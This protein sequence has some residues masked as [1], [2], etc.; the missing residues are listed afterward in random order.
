[1]RA[2]ANLDAK[3]NWPP[4]VLAAEK[5]NLQQ[6]KALIRS[7]ADL[8]AP[9]PLDQTAPHDQWRATALIR[10]CRNGF[11]NVARAL[12]DAG[13]DVNAQLYDKRTALDLAATYDH[14]DVVKLLLAHHARG[15]PGFALGQPISNG[16]LAIVQALVEHRFPVKSEGWAVRLAARG[17]HREILELLLRNGASPN[18]AEEHTGWTALMLACQST[19]HEMARL[20][21]EA[22]A[23]VNAINVS[24]QTAL[25]FAAS[26]ENPQS[27]RL[28]LEA[29]ADP[30]IRDKEGLTA[31]D[32]AREEKNRELVALLESHKLQDAPRTPKQRAARPAQ[33][34]EGRS[35]K[36]PKPGELPPHMQQFEKIIRDL[37]RM[38]G[39]SANPCLSNGRGQAAAVL[40]ELPGSAATKL[41]RRRPQLL[42]RGLYLFRNELPFL[43]PTAAS[44]ALMPAADPYQVLEA[45]QPDA[46]NYGL[47]VA[48]LIRAMRNIEKVSA[49]DLVG[50]GDDFIELQFSPGAEAS[51][52]ARLL[53]EIPA[54]YVDIKGNE[55][56]NISQIRTAITKHKYILL[57]WE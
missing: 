13:A 15:T 42:K 2:K 18:V 45:A 6:V 9:T 56:D 50:A 28:L 46:A 49:F 55:L 10:A 36:K 32:Y 53:M 31:V 43:H 14:L 48:A 57:Y 54:E 19:D 11:L 33:P 27:C 35:V 3:S 30:G 37:E 40:F 52:I 26:Y 44:F 41:L 20:L 39:V 24:G 4:L 21:I 5:G 25:H 38:T 17:E 47:T 12:L 1:M 7:G 8:N 34:F 51:K 23:S 16:Y 22:G 29:G